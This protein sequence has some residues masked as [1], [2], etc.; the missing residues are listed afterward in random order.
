MIIRKAQAKDVNQLRKA[1]TSVKEFK[2]SKEV[3]T[4]WPKKVLLNIIKS[5]KDFILVAEENNSIIGFVIVNFNPNFGKAIIENIFVKKEFRGK[6]VGKQLL[7]KALERL[8]KLKCNYICALVESK[9]KAIGFYLEN[10]FNKGINC[11]WMDKILSKSF[12]K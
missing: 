11:V 10:E 4:F 8:R 9:N 2:V 3:V 12:K 5:R 1:G 6:N 7:E